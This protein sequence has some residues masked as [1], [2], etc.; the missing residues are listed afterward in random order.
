MAFGGPS[1]VALSAS[2]QTRRP[3]PVPA[4]APTA[5]PMMLRNA[6]ELRRREKMSAAPYQEACETLANRNSE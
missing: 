3:V 2:H 5:E 1:V 4:P 6:R